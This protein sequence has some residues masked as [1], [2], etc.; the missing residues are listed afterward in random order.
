SFAGPF[1]QGLDATV[2][3][4]GPA[5]EHDALDA[6][7]L[8]A[9]GERQPH[10]LGLLGL[11]TR[12]PEALAVRFGDGDAFGVVDDLG[13]DALGAAEDREAQ[14]AR[15]DGAAEAPAG[16]VGAP[17]L[18]D[19]GNHAHSLC[20]GSQRAAVLPALRRTNSPSYLTPLPWYL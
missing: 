14:P 11:V 1:G 18:A 10:L 4:E 7:G 17:F 20:L 3:L 13:V 9:L 19:D 16:A 6:G 5:V 8:G 2:V 15:V 12:E